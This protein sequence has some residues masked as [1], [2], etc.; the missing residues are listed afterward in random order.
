V[1]LGKRMS[2]TTT[3]LPPRGQARAAAL[4]ADGATAA[5]VPELTSRLPA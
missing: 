5:T 1:N 3:G 4:E 2:A